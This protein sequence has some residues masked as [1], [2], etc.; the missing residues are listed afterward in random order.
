M[1]LSD[2]STAIAVDKATTMK[3]LKGVTKGLST[4]EDT[5]GLS[6]AFGGR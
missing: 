1:K 6:P 2:F 5:K 4:A 3:E